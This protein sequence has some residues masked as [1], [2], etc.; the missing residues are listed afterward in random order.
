MLASGV[1]IPTVA[2]I[3]GHSHNVTTL[4]V[5]AHAVPLNLNHAVETIQR[6]V[7]GARNS[8]RTESHAER[9]AEENV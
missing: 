4:D 1:D 5:Y 7:R 2:A 8:R 6:A 9:P 3:L